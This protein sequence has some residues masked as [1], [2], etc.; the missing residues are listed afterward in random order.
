MVSLSLELMV[1]C[2]LEQ[3]YREPTALDGLLKRSDVERR[4]DLVM[5]RLVSQSEQN[6]EDLRVL[7]RLIR[8]APYRLDSKSDVAA[9]LIAPAQE[10]EH[11]KLK[12]MR[13]IWNR[14]VARTPALADQLK[15]P[16]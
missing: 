14:I 12:A 3:A 7:D 10:D 9:R 11:E 16:T 8:F 1:T 5:A 13:P 15:T 4:A 6:R 2:V